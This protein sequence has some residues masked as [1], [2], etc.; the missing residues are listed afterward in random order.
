MWLGWWLN[1][2]RSARPHREGTL[3]MPDAALPRL[4]L[5]G[6]R[7]GSGKTVVTLG[8]IG[9]FRGQGL[10]VA[11]FKKGPDYIDPAWLKL[12]AGQECYNLDAFLMPPADVPASLLAHGAGA[13]LALIEGNRGLYDGMDAAGTY[14]TAELA[15]LIDAPVVLIADCTKSTRTVA[16]MV[17]GCRAMDSDVQLAGV[18]LNHVA[19]SRQESVIRRAIQRDCDV[20]VFGVV[21]RIRGLALTERY[22]GLLPPAEHSDCRRIVDTLTEAVCENVDLPALK[23]LADSAGPVPESAGHRDGPRLRLFG[24]GLRIAV[25]HDSA[26]HFYY[27]E[28]LQALERSGVELVD[29][30]AIHDRVMPDVDGVYIGGGFP[31]TH[32]SLLAGNETFRRSLRRRVEEGL[33]VYAECGGLI[34][35]AESVA[36]DGRDWP[37]VGVFGVQFTVDRRPQGHGYEVIRV[38]ASNPWFDAGTELRGHEFRYCRVTDDRASR[39]QSAAAVERGFGFDGQRDGLVYKNV[40]ACFCHVHATGTPQWVEAMIRQAAEHRAAKGDLDRQAGLT[41]APATG[42]SS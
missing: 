25:I 15:K 40:W 17:L 38:D 28:N 16:A 11:P 23:Q 36:V 34:Y 14:S 32:A 7:G 12:A 41:H 29:V 2:L 5:S 3:R 13:D 27:P 26:F 33:P 21:P 18:I 24:A 9:G 35:L 39:G 6:L 20:E 22:L 19:S 8:L 4:V 37:M 1:G 31:E 30:S 10:C 42:L